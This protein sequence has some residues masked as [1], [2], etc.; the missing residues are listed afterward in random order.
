MWKR[1]EA[2]KPP[3]PATRSTSGPASSARRTESASRHERRTVNIGTS[4]VIKGELS[5][6][7]DLTVEGQVEGTI[8]LRQHVLTIGPHGRIKAQV[9]ARAMVIEGQVTGD[10]TASERIDIRDH[11][12]VDGDLVAPRVTIA[13]GAHFCGSIDMPR[14]GTKSAGEREHGE[15]PHAVAAPAP[16]AATQARS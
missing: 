11:G 8:E 1:D 12:S 2:V 9:A 3:Q 16:V 6:S 5:G 15:N 4:V 10:L 7:E 13:D 14:Q